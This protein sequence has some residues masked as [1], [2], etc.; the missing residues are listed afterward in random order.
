MCTQSDTCEEVTRLKV[1]R[2][3]SITRYWSVISG[4]VALLITLVA[5]YANTVNAMDQVRDHE[6]RLRELERVV[7]SSEALL[8]RISSRIIEI[9]GKL[10]KHIEYNYNRQYK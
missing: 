7:I 4:L 6:Q 9:D 2:R 1:D 3:S 8:Q 5:F 10:D